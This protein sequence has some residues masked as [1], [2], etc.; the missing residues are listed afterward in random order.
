M[1][2]TKAPLANGKVA[3]YTNG[4]TPEMASQFDERSETKDAKE[5]KTSSVRWTVGLIVR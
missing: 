4:H 3:V 1:M 5:S 2:A